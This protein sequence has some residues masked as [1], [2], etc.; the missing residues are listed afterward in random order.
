MHAPLFVTTLCVY[1]EEVVRT[2]WC[3][4]LGWC[5]SFSNTFLD[6]LSTSPAGCVFGPMWP[7]SPQIERGS[8]NL[9]VD[10]TTASQLRPRSLLNIGFRRVRGIPFEP[11]W[12]NRSMHCCTSFLLASRGARQ[13][14]PL[15]H[16]RE[17]IGTDSGPCTIH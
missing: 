13:E 6:A 11:L 5:S 15:K 14:V 16:S 7:A 10:G 1:H 9:C 2:V 8:T 3:L 12:D 17:S 4:S